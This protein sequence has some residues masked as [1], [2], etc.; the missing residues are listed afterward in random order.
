MRNTTCNATPAQ[1]LCQRGGNLVVGVNAVLWMY[2]FEVVDVEALHKVF[3]NSIKT[4]SI[5]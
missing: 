4:G 2:R 5:L 3:P 1:P